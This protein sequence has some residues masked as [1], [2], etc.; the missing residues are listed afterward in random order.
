M[1]TALMIVGIVINIATVLYMWRW[2]VR[3]NDEFTNLRLQ[4]E[5]RLTELDGLIADARRQ[6]SSDI[7]EKVK[8]N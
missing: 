6:P 4:Q 2:H 1:I 5:L 7:A 8:W 3:I